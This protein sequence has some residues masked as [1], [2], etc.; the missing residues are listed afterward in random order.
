MVK[1][2]DHSSTVVIKRK[3]ILEPS[4]LQSD[5]KKRVMPQE[6]EASPMGLQGPTIWLIPGE[7]LDY[8]IWGC[9]LGF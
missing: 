9:L 5:T 6:P 8:T 7:I 1:I 2:P 4:H 3:H